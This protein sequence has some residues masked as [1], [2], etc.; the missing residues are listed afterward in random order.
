MPFSLMHNT[1]KPGCSVSKLF[2][3]DFVE[4][5]TSDNE[6]QP[7]DDKIRNFI[8]VN[9]ADAGGRLGSADS[10]SESRAAFTGVLGEIQVVLARGEVHIEITGR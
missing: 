10:R 8:R 4:C 5:F 6:R 3:G 1:A 2:V 9:S 7:K